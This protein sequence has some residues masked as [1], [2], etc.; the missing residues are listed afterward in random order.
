MESGDVERELGGPSGR[1]FQGLCYFFSDWPPSHLQLK[2][3]LRD[4]RRVAASR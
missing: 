4:L 3:S 2:N 1:L